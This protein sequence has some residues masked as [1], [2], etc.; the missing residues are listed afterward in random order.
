MALFYFHIQDGADLIKDEDGIDLLSADHAR[1]VAIQSARELCSKAIKTGEELK[2][3]AIVVADEHGRQ[4]VAVPIME[5]LPKR[6][7][8]YWSGLIGMPRMTMA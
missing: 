2:A 7:R 4:L 1:E 8:S 6:F 3:D 5:A